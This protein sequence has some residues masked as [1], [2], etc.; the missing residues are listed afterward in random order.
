[1]HRAILGSEGEEEGFP[2][3]YYIFTYAPLCVSLFLTKSETQETSDPN[4]LL[5]KVVA[6]NPQVVK[7]EKQKEYFLSSYL[8]LIYLLVS[9]CYW[10]LSLELHELKYILKCYLIKI[11]TRKGNKIYPF[12][13]LYL[14]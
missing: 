6:Q 3:D 14:H 7:R 13:I 10:L 5:T 9:T 8:G 4:K 2:D 12:I 11:F 1:M